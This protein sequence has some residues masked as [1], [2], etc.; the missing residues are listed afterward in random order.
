MSTKEDKEQIAQNEA[1]EGSDDDDVTD[2]KGK[3][4]SK[5]QKKKLKAK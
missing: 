5:A 2:E 3:P 4:L 1:A